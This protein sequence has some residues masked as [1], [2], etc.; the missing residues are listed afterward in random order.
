[1]ARWVIRVPA[2]KF[3]VNETADEKGVPISELFIDIPDD[4]VGPAFVEMSKQ[5]QKSMMRTARE[6]LPPVIPVITKYNPDGTKTM[7]RL[8]P[9]VAAVP[10][11]LMN[12]RQEK[13]AQKPIPKDSVGNIMPKSHS[14]RK[15]TSAIETILASQNKANQKSTKLSSY[16]KIVLAHKEADEK[17]KA[18]RAEEAEKLKAEQESGLPTS[19]PMLAQI[20]GESISQDGAR[21][22]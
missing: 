10:A 11:A 19:H 9:K 13:L 17:K 18:A 6:N 22:E 7:E 16:D 5:L 2:V 3:S 21:H 1:M 12:H 14:A 15:P 8:E 4:I 20:V